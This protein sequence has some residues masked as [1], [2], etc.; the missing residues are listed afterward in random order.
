MV[1][2][3][4]PGNKYAFLLKVKRD[5]G[6]WGMVGKHTTYL[7]LSDYEDTFNLLHKHNNSS[8]SSSIDFFKIS[9]V[10][11]SLSSIFWLILLV[12]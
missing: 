2:I 9:S 8:Y 12:E 10:S 11:I 1:N 4:R 3:I 6:G 7:F 5:D